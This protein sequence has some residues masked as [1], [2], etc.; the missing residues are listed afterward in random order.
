MYLQNKTVSGRLGL[1]GARATALAIS[2]SEPGRE[3]AL[4]NGVATNSPTKNKH[5]FLSA[6]TRVTIVLFR[7]LVT[8]GTRKKSTANWFK[9]ESPA[10]RSMLMR[11]EAGITIRSLLQKLMYST[12]SS[13]K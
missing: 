2:E 3:F 8:A 10:G 4:L 13:V 9:W 5:A 7:L 6:R 12:K 11:P 1:S